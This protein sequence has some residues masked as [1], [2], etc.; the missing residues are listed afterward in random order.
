MKSL[1]RS[2]FGLATALMVVWLIWRGLLCFD[3]WASFSFLFLLCGHNPVELGAQL[4]ACSCVKP[5]LGKELGDRGGKEESGE[6]QSRERSEYGK[7]KY[8][9]VSKGKI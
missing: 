5:H 7:R 9:F 2:S 4:L 3:V 6:G 1:K 8:D